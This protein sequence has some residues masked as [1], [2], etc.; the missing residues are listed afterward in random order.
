MDPTEKK[1]VLTKRIQR[2]F[3]V[4]VDCDAVIA[5]GTLRLK[6][7]QP[8]RLTRKNYGQRV[9]VLGRPGYPVVYLALAVG[10]EPQEESIRHTG[11]IP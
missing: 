8:K 7:S 11:A 10:I 3:P 4:A 1:Q 5:G 9:C 2:R 6:H